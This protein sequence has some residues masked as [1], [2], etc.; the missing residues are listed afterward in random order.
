MAYSKAQW[1]SN[2][3]KASPYFQPSFIANMS[4]KKKLL[5]GVLILPFH[6][7]VRYKKFNNYNERGSAKSF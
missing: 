7:I 5:H 6:K 4:K 1:K 3:E 2:G